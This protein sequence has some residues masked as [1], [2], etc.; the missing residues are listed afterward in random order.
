MR[1]TSKRGAMMKDRVAE[2]IVEFFQGIGFNPL[3][4]ITVVCILITLSYWNDFKNWSELPGWNK[5]L[6][7]SA[8][9]ASVVLLIFSL[10]SLFGVADF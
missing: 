1:R 7:A 2:R 3:Y 4:A 9:L 8:V 6:A 10:L 5:R